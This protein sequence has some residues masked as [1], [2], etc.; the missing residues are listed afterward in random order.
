MK[1]A[2]EEAGLRGQTVGEPLGEYRDTKWGTKL[3]VIVLMMEV[4]A[5]DDHWHE[6]DIRQRRWVSPEDAVALLSKR[7]LR[8]FTD[9]ALRQLRADS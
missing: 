9:A 2:F 4:T 3:R 5:C 8:R 1:E 7:K 6:A